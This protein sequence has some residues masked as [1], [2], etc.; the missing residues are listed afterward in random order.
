MRHGFRSLAVLALA[1]IASPA[2]G[3]HK[4]YYTT[5]VMPYTTAAV[6]PGVTQ[7]FAP[8]QVTSVPVV[9]G[10][11]QVSTPVVSGV[12]AVSVPLVAGVTQLSTPLVASVNLVSA[13]QSFS[14]QQALSS[15]R[16]GDPQ[17]PDGSS[18]S[19]SGG[20]KGDTA[21]MR[22]EL[23]KM[24][25]ELA[26]YHSDIKQ[27]LGGIRKGV[28]A[29]VAQRSSDA[30]MQQMRTLIKEELDKALVPVQND[31]KDLKSRVGNLEKPKPGGG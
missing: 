2:F 11:T 18:G 22:Q 9:S 13:P 3:W 6:V 20:G 17:G 16:S 15:P 10:V 28:E 29:L 26:A 24:R 8:L 31:L 19:P 4:T 14:N 25:E 30:A 21:G 7:V 27:E 23:A 12:S 5:A 1:G